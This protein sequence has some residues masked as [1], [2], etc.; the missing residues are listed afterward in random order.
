MIEFV[1]FLIVFT[2][3]CLNGTLREIK[4]LMDKEDE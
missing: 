2:L 1:L 3:L 4:D